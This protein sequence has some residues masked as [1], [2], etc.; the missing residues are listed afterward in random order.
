LDRLI[1]AFLLADRPEWIHEI[2]YDGY[3]LRVE[4]DG[5]R[6]RLITRRGYNWTKR[7]P[8]IAR[9]ALK[10][11]HKQFALDGEAVI[12][13]VDG[14]SD[15]NALHSGKLNHEVQ[16]YAFDVLAKGDDVRPLPFAQSE[17]GKTV[18]PS[19]G[20]HLYRRLRQGEIGPAR[21][22]QE[23]LRIRTR[24]PRLEARRSPPS[25]PIQAAIDYF[26]SMIAAI[27]THAVA[28]KDRR[29]WLGSSE[30]TAGWLDTAAV[31]LGLRPPG[32]GRNFFRACKC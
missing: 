9:A 16:L 4:R 2:K 8:W 25:T 13:G 12:L 23:S 18:A 22:I 15:F 24:G 29:L 28:R 21:P 32:A 5:D 10:N 17:L 11:R 7:F 3:P 14:I 27:S 6:V 1:F 31:S 26:A 30:A 19:A 20:W